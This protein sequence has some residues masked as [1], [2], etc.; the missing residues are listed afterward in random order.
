MMVRRKDVICVS[1]PLF[2]EK[3]NAYRNIFYEVFPTLRHAG[4]KIF[5]LNSILIYHV[6]KILSKHGKILCSTHSFPHLWHD[7]GPAKRI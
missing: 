4:V 1:S 7:T 6:A 3:N 5:L 2:T